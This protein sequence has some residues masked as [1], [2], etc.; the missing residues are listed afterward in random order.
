MP[1]FARWRLSGVKQFVRPYRGPDQKDPG[2]G[3]GRFAH[4]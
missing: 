2:D 1:A 3:S 4:V